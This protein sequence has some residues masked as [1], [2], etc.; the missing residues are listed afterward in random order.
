MSARSELEPSAARRTAVTGRVRASSFKRRTATESTSA[1]IRS[2]EPR[3]SVSPTGF[4][5]SASYNVAVSCTESAPLPTRAPNTASRAP[6]RRAT[7][8]ADA[9]SGGPLQRRSTIEGGTVRKAPAPS[10]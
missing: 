3:S 10:S 2:A 1:S 7:S 5:A 9:A 6:V 8:L 4:R